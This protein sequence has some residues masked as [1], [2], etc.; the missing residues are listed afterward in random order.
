MK[1][2]L[3]GA[4]VGER[5]FPLT[6]SL[7][8]P[9]IPVL[10]RPI[11]LQIL[12][13]LGKAGV[14]EAVLNLHHLPEVLPK[15]LGD[16]RDQ[17][18]PRIHYS[19]EETI[20]GTAGGVRKAAD[21]LAGSDPIVVIN[22]DSLSEVD[23][24][25]AVD[26][27]RRSQ[28]LA[29]LVLAP[30]RDAYSRVDV[31]A[32]GRIIS[33]AGR[34][35]V[36]AERRAASFLFTGCQI[37]AEE[38]LHGIPADARCLVRDVYRNLAAEGRL[39]SFVHEGFWWEFGSP[40]LYLEGSLR[41]LD[42]LRSGDDGIVDHDPVR[43]VDQAVAAVGAGAKFHDDA[44]FVGRAGLGFASYVSGGCAVQDSVVMPEAWVGPD[45]RLTR[46]VVGPGAEIPAGFTGENLLLCADRLRDAQ[47]PP[48]VTRRD[49]LLIHRFD[50]G[51]R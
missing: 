44:R 12:R 29:T 11:A 3:L 4:G 38:L 9:A 23:L 50:A 17:A 19:H 42:L 30:H 5:M 32:Q 40:K 28:M 14:D 48:G 37:I 31:D 1:A 2:M 49:G 21:R 33:L 18:L 41:L 36:D 16:G 8:K 24:G 47:C 46:A 15:L 26:H 45:C 25:A 20:L 10:G 51:S 35:E 43:H 27:H 7:P 22:A 6:L 39:G 34:P 13:Q